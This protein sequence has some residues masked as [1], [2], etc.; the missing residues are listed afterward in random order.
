ML[1]V[2]A[3][4]EAASHRAHAVA[5]PAHRKASVRHPAPPRPIGRRVDAMQLAAQIATVH[6]L[7][8]AWTSAVIARAHHLPEVLELIAPPAQPA[9]KNWAAY[10]ARFVEPARIGAGVSFWNAH[11]GWLDAARSRYGVEPSVIIGII[12]V[13]TYYGRLTGRF[14][15]VD[16]LAT[17]ALDRPRGGSDR[18]AFFADELGHW[19]AIARRERIDPAATQ[20]SFAGAIGLGQFMPGS[21]ERWAIDFDGDGR[22]D[23]MADAADVIGSIANYLA[24]HGW[25]AGTP[26]HFEVEPPPAGSEARA[27]LL[28]PDIVPSFSARQFAEAG[29]ELDPSGREFDGPL[30]LVELR[31]GAQETPSYV[32]A[33]ANFYAVTRYNRSAY[34][35]MA[36]IELGRAVQAQRAGEP[37]KPADR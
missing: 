2:A 1:L 17:L 37:A 34:Y 23:M 8:P 33:T 21:I 29:A 16:A 15:V 12:G 6:D 25:Q 7:D 11:Q 19:L 27:R 18:R 3:P 35:A 9:S 24:G 28:G 13:E 22:I 31:N 10:R 32:A 30:A 26:T 20:G 14:R 4:V 5:K 36:V